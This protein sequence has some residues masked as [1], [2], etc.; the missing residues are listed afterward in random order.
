M[1]SKLAAIRR[2]HNKSQ[3]E[4]ADLIGVDVRTYINKE[5]GK[6]QFKANEMFIIAKYFGKTIEEIFLPEN[7]ENLEVRKGVG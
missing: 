1:Q 3:K 7:F 4:I 5:Q 6:T 2:Y